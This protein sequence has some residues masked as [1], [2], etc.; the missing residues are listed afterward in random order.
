M[1][2]TA[3]LDELAR[4]PRGEMIADTQGNS[5]NRILHVQDIC[6]NKTDENCDMG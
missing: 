5:P 6:I 1:C 4:E 3:P 2:G